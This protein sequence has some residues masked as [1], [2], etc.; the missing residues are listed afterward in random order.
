MLISSFVE[1]AHPIIHGHPIQ[2]FPDRL[3]CVYQM[4]F[5]SLEHFHIPIDQI[6]QPNKRVSMAESRAARFQP[7]INSFSSMIKA[8]YFLT[9]YFIDLKI[10]GSDWGSIT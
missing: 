9:Q 4:G 8:G 3:N 6:S 5:D 7:T 10:P 1:F 2:N